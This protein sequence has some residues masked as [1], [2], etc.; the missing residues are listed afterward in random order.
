MTTRKLYNPSRYSR[1]IRISE[2]F[3]ADSITATDLQPNDKKIRLC[4]HNEDIQSG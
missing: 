2:T 4:N 1:T 3:R